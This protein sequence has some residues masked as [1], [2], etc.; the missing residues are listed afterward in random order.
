MN[1]V[2][3]RET[4]GNNVSSLYVTVC[5]ET[6]GKTAGQSSVTHTKESLSSPGDLC[7]LLL[8]LDI[9]SNLSAGVSGCVCTHTYLPALVWHA[10]VHLHPSAPF[11]CTQRLVTPHEMPQQLSGEADERRTVRNDWHSVS[12][13][14]CQR[15]FVTSEVAPVSLSPGERIVFLTDCV[16]TVSDN[17]KST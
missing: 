7:V 9:F 14:S 10:E 13:S 3:E 16:S 5:K 17:H 11:V 12:G 1:P 8:S 4:Q 2:F 6:R 15:A